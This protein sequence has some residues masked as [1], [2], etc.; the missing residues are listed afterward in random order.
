MDEGR[1]FDHVEVI[2]VETPEEQA[3]W[4][5]DYIHRA[6]LGYR[7]FSSWDDQEFYVQMVVEKATLKSLFDPV[8]AEFHV[9]LATAG[10]WSD[11]SM[12]ADMMRRFSAHENAGKQC[13]LLYCGDHDPGGLRISDCLR[14][15]MEEL[16]DAIEWSPA[17]LIID[18]FGL[19]FDFIEANKLVWIEN[20]ITGNKGQWRGVCLSDPKHP[21]HKKEYVQSYLAKYGAPKV[22]GEASGQGAGGR[23]GAL[24]RS[25]PPIRQSGFDF[26]LRGKARR[27]ARQG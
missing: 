18:R 4:I 24:P 27:R 23:S 22:E 1:A 16:A 8:C 14:T 26:D 20:L 19:N 10:G 11:L 2:D 12:R 5:V 3:K 25:N 15:N 17:N 21:D 7:P 9:P 13:V 6:H